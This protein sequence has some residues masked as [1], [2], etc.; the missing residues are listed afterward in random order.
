LVFNQAWAKRTGRDFKVDA[1]IE[2]RW[3]AFRA[4]LEA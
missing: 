3:G 1:V 4:T 2:R